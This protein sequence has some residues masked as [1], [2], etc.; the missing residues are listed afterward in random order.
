LKTPFSNLKASFS[1]SKESLATTIISNYEPWECLRINGDKTGLVATWTLDNLQV[2]PFS[3]ILKCSDLI[4][5]FL[6]QG[7]YKGLN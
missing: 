4:F 2:S 1:N 7:S 5:Y 6:L 3:T